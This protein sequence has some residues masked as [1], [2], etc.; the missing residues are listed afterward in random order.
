MPQI[1]GGPLEVKSGFSD[2]V[3]S[4]SGSGETKTEPPASKRQKT[5]KSPTTFYT[6]DSFFT[7]CDMPEKSNS[8]WSTLELF[9]YNDV[10][11]GGELEYA[12]EAVIYNYVYHHQTCLNNVLFDGVYKKN[13]NIKS[14]T[15]IAHADTKTKTGHNDR[16]PTWEHSN[17]QQEKVFSDTK[18]VENID[19]W[20]TRTCKLSD[21]TGGTVFSN[22][23]H[24][25]ECEHQHNL[26]NDWKS[27]I[28]VMK[29]GLFHPKIYILRFSRILRIIVS[30]RNLEGGWEKDV[31]WARDF[32]IDPD[33]GLDWY[34]NKVTAEDSFFKPLDEFFK[35]TT[36]NVNAENNDVLYKRTK[37]IFRG[38]VPG[39]TLS[40]NDDTKVS[41]IASYGQLKPHDKPLKNLREIMVRMK[42][43]GDP[44]AKLQITTCFVG[45]PMSTLSNWWKDLQKACLVDDVLESKVKLVFP[46][47]RNV[48]ELETIAGFSAIHMYFGPEGVKKV[49]KDM[50][51]L[52]TA[53][54]SDKRTL[55]HIK[56]YSRFSGPSNRSPDGEGTIAWVMV[57]S[58]NCSHRAWGDLQKSSHNIEA[59][60]VLETKSSVISNDWKNRHPFKLDEC[61]P[62][63]ELPISSEYYN[64]PYTWGKSPYKFQSDIRYKFNDDKGEGECISWLQNVKNNYKMRARQTFTKHDSPIRDDECD[65]WYDENKN[66]R[67]GLPTDFEDD[68]ENDF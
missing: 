23:F 11:S 48:F 61:T 31:G 65:E 15:L 38:I 54:L 29:N 52:C 19:D 7:I 17:S 45:N 60:V 12:E 25:V 68:S 1:L 27:Y 51:Y 59:S 16:I 10:S 5:E 46:S 37:D 9:T 56:M 43:A 66:A 30:S 14:Y 36:S 3:G 67:R 41:F 50:P 40:E 33:S 26:G 53:K 18:A 28:C 55:Y 22:A 6:G 47:W 32:V 20:S 64:D 58:H 21:V 39:S 4:D 2:F 24:V 42:W 57:G 44:N 34:N 8:C 35:I 13:Q 63:A 62:Y 49:V